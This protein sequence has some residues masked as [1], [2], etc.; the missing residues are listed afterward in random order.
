MSRERRRV[1]LR[2]LALLV[3]TA[4]GY[5]LGEDWVRGRE[6]AASLLLLRATGAAVSPG[7][8]TSIVVDHSP[9]CIFTA[10][11]TPACS[12]WASVL[13]L[14]FLVLIIPRVPPPRRLAAALAAAAVVFAGN[15]GSRS[16]SAEISR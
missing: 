3:L 5:A 7:A 11:L 4:A 6:T 9:G 8:G 14:V 1:M 15:M 13:A 16:Y 2:V 10:T 12:A